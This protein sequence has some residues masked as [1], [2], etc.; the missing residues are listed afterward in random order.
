MSAWKAAFI[1]A[2]G[3][4]CLALALATILVPMAV[5]EYRGLWLAGL[6]FAT[7]CVGTLFAIFLNRADRTFK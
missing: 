1:V 2:F 7:V 4:V 5:D 3:F 6:L